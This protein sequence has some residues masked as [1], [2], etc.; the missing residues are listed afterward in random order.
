MSKLAL[1]SK[2][3][4]PIIIAFLMFVAV[5]VAACGNKEKVFE[6]SGNIDFQTSGANASVSAE[7]ENT[8]SHSSPA[9]VVVNDGG[10]SSESQSWQNISFSFKQSASAV[11]KLKFENLSAEEAL[12]FKVK[13]QNQVDNLSIS[14][15][16][17]Y[18]EA[19]DVYFELAPTQTGVC[20]IA[21]SVNSDADITSQFNLNIEIINANQ[22]PTEGIEVQVLPNIAALG[23]VQG[24][25]SYNIGDEI[26][27]TATE[28]EGNE[29][30]AWATST[31]P[32]TMQ[33][34][35]T[36]PN[37]KFTFGVSSPRTIY[38]LFNAT[39]QIRFNSGDLR[40]TLYKETKLAEV[41]ATYGVGSTDV[42]EIPA[43]VSDGETYYQV[44]SVADSAFWIYHDIETVKLPNTIYKFGSSVFSNSYDIKYLEGEGNS[45]YQ[46][47]DNRAI[48]TDGETIAGY[49]P[50][51]PA[52]EF[53]IPENVKYI[54]TS[55]FR[56]SQLKVV[57]ASDSNLISIGASAFEECRQLTSIILPNSLESISNNAFRNCSNL[58]GINLPS[59]LQELG[60]YAFYGCDLDNIVYESANTTGYTYKDGVLTILDMSSTGWKN[61]TLPIT[62]VIFPE[63]IT[64]IPSN[65]F[66]ACNH[67]KNIVIPDTITTIGNSA[68]Y[69]C[70]NLQSVTI[71]SN[72][73]TIGN[74]AFNNC[75]NLTE[76]NFNATNLKDLSSS[77]GVFCNAG[78]NGEGITVNFGDNVEKVPDYLF[79]PYYSSWYAASYSPNIKQINWN[80]VTQ[81]GSYAF[82]YCAGL[83]NITLSD[84][85]TTIG[86]SAFSG[87]TQLN[88][89]T[90]ESVSLANNI[91]SSSSLGYLLNYL[92]SEWG[93]VRVKCDDLAQI[94]SSYLKGS[95]FIQPTEIV[96]GYAIFEKK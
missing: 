61:T 47:Y 89:V 57:D 83:E 96:N 43:S 69:N 71:G 76:I 56:N 2:I 25:G 50:A 5:I 4:M 39:T 95:T 94:T 59:T 18:L 93:T 91:T 37:Y 64:E 9:T 6:I 92:I 44:Y 24:G 34:L 26:S 65:M 88:R 40:Y 21:F 77:N 27:L 30:L 10:A 49:A 29:F 36:S 81:I 33:V 46:I 66:S 8:E 13:N 19:N 45:Y 87:C 7:F 11:L 60:F 58:G 28:N 1:K 16:K 52:T 78:Q 72:V 90:I 63:G 79:C 82:S 15:K 38:A 23:S 14:L 67:L 22:A 51:N 35:S 54:G 53:K 62:Q 42:F 70:K 75:T 3:F 32:K 86:S 85:I 84:K 48:I 74:S 17:D 68:F 12:L 41:T 80:N 73:Q 55:A 20:E 31:D